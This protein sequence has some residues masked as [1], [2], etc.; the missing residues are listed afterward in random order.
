MITGVWI[1][2][3]VEDVVLLFFGIQ[4][5]Y[6][7]AGLLG[8][9][10]WVVPT[11]IMVSNPAIQFMLYETLL[12]K[13]KKKRASNLKGA[14]GLTALECTGLAIYIVYLLS[15]FYLLLIKLV[16]TLICEF[17]NFSCAGVMYL[18]QF[19]EQNGGKLPER[20]EYIKTLNDQRKR[21]VKALQEKMKMNKKE[22]DAFPGGAIIFTRVLNLLRT[23]LNVRIVYLDI[24]KPF[25]ESTLLGLNCG[26]K[27][28]YE[29]TIANIWP[30]F[31]TNRKE[32]IKHAS[33]KKLQ[34][35][36]E[37]AI[38]HPLHI[39]GELYI[40]IPPGWRTQLPD[41]ASGAGW[42][43]STTARIVIQK[44][45]STWCTAGSF[46]GLTTRV[47]T[48]LGTVR[49]DIQVFDLH[50]GGDPVVHRIPVAA[51]HPK[52]VL[53]REKF[54][55]YD[56]FCARLFFLGD[57]PHVVLRWWNV[58]VRK[59]EMAV[60]V[61]DPGNP[62]GWRVRRFTGPRA[63]CRKWLRRARAR[64][65]RRRRPDRKRPRLLREES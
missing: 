17:Q 10:K 39:E 59:D 13:L 42:R 7:E 64:H 60:F 18:G 21:N 51:L 52:L 44:R 30:K 63:A 9:W 65:R 14:D 22:V 26:T 6:K 31:G 23:S 54:P 35:V 29:E 55:S 12:K 3:L 53:R 61:S 58:L 34:E 57:T 48:F 32:L 1:L 2:V 37:E 15:P 56:V 33:G 47:G 5:L 8:F 16:M 4:D 45:S 38:V 40:G 62:L 24:M 27:L 36:L 41:S 20:L 49:Y 28:K 46:F 19:I 25:A 43:L 11:L 50:T